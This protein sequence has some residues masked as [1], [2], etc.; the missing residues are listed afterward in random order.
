[1][2]RAISVA[3]LCSL[4][5]SA[6][7]ASDDAT[8]TTGAACPGELQ[9]AIN[10]GVFFD[11]CRVLTTDT[12]PKVG[13]PTADLI[14]YKNKDGFDPWSGAKDGN[15]MPLR[16]LT[17]N[18]NNKIAKIYASLADVPYRKPIATSVEDTQGR[19]FNVKTG[20]AAVVQNNVSKGWTK[21]WVKQAISASEL[22][23]LQFETF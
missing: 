16:K 2:R 22:L 14:V 7:C 13:L 15:T 9:V 20:N 5:F 4:A 17:E 8:G 12:L 1:M 6:A 11:E 18:D 21:V 23:V 3:L 19:F 10:Q